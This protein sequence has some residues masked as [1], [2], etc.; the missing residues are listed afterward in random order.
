MPLV[1]VFVPRTRRNQFIEFSDVAA[2]LTIT[3]SAEQLAELGIGRIKIRR[4]RVRPDGYLANGCLHCDAILG[5][6]PLR[7]D[8]NAFLAEGGT[9]GELVAGTI[10]LH[11]RHR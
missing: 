2:R 8:L 1:G 6:H 7:E 5:E 10:P 3:V 9:L 4:S 11:R